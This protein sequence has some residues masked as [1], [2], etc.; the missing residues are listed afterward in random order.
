[1]KRATLNLLAWWIAVLRTLLLGKY[2]DSTACRGLLRL[3][4]KTWRQPS[5]GIYMYIYIFMCKNWHRFI[6][7]EGEDAVHLWSLQVILTICNW[8]QLHFITFL[9]HEY[10]HDLFWRW[11]DTDGCGW[12]GYVLMYYVWQQI[13]RF[14]GPGL[15]DLLQ[16]LRNLWA[17]RPGQTQ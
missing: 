6:R 8:C 1:M 15:E 5:H 13:D 7:K 17:D 14:I 4:K 9:M 16:K 10:I 11:M 12:T 3:R 2:L